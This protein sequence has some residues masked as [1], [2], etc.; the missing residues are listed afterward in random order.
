MRRNFQ[1]FF[2]LLCVVAVIVGV[3]SQG[4][5]PRPPRAIQGVFDA[6][7]RN[8]DQQAALKLNGE[9]NL[10]WQRF[11]DPASFSGAV[12]PKPDGT[13][14]VPGSWDGSE[15]NGEKVDGKGYATLHLRVLVPP[16]GAPLGLRLNAFF[17]SNR[18]WV[19]GQLLSETGRVAKRAEDSAMNHSIQIVALPD[20]QQL[21]IVLHVSNFHMRQSGTSPIRIGKL[22]DLR[23]EQQRNWVLAA[24]SIGTLLL[25]AF[26][27]LA[28]YLMRRRNPSP[29][30]FALNCLFWSVFFMSNE[31]SGWLIRMFIPQAGGEILFRVWPVCLFMASAFSFQFYRSIYPAEFPRWMAQA[32]WG[33]SG[34]Y[35]LVAIVTPIPV[36]ILALPGYYLVTMVRM[37][38]TAWALF[39]AARR[40]RVGALIILDGYLL[41]IVLSVND[42]LYGMD[43]IRSVLVLHLG[44]IIYMFTQALA[45]ARR[46]SALFASVELLSSELVES[47]EVLNEEIAERTRLQQEV[48]TVSEEER[49]R[50]SHVLHDGLCQQLTGARL[51]CSGLAAQCA[52]KEPGGQDLRELAQLLDETVDQ[53]HE[54]SRGLWPMEL[55]S[56]DIVEALANLIQ[57]QRSSSGLAIDFVRR[58]ACA[59]CAGSKAVQIYG[60][61]R[62]AIAN[63]VKHAQ[64]RRIVVTL[65][66]DESRMITLSVAD[67]GVGRS[68]ARQSKDGLGLRIMTYR[69]RTAGGEISIED[70]EGGGTLVHCSIPGDSRD[71]T[72]DPV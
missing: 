30:Y 11:V 43:L 48:I 47:N 62:E 42:M 33:I 5:D 53:A 49:R 50:I 38:Y 57:R 15:F 63:A 60:I 6:R 26:Y 29:L 46:F 8:F 36:L 20:A 56:E 2:L 3:H 9:W 44:M 27:H 28:L 41:M 54:L 72:A 12:P 10:Y 1:I 21:D 59:D 16:F 32:L 40:R 67:D 55:E 52:D 34:V 64:A 24:F 45:L 17:P 19:N 66:C 68:A 39:Q 25:M 13:M 23:L 65:D 37:V 58:G 4:Q 22:D 7:E 51:R 69:A 70:R 61:A 35:V 18:I 14:S 31:S 71:L